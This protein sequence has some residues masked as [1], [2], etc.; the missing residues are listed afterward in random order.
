MARDAIIGN[1]RA[2]QAIYKEIG[3]MAAHPVP[4]LIRGDTGT[5]KELVARAV[6]QHSDRADKPFISVNCAAIPDTLLESEL[7]GHERGAFTGADARRSG[8][9]SRPIGG[10]LFLDEIGD[11]TAHTQAKLL[12]FSRSDASS[13]WEAANRS[14]SMCG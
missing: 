1:S 11:L 14:R 3:Q 2:M 9:S 7:F 10:A 5:G 8:A 6:Y 12:R 13:A 4:V